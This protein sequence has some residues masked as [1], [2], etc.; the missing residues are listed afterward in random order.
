MGKAVISKVFLTSWCPFPSPLHNQWIVALIVLMCHKETI[1]RNNQW[2]QIKYINLSQK[3]M[4]HKQAIDLYCESAEAGLSAVLHLLAL[5]TNKNHT[6]QHIWKLFQLIERLFKSCSIRH[7]SLTTSELCPHMRNLVKRKP[8]LW[9]C[10][11]L[12]FNCINSTGPGT[13]HHKSAKTSGRI[14]IFCRSH[15]T[16]ATQFRN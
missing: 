8:S 4:H 1:Q 2:G 6:T 15:T 10:H 7:K 5:S 3:W 12:N 9:E 14:G 11:S 13:Y 16:I